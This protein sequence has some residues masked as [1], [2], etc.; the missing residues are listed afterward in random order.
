M[1]YYYDTFYANRDFVHFASDRHYIRQLC[2]LLPQPSTSRVLDVG[3]ARG[4]WTRLFAECGVGSVSGIDNSRVGVTMSHRHFPEGNFVVGDATMLP[5]ADE[6]F[7]MVFCQG[8]SCFNVT[9]LS[10]TVDIGR[11]LLRCLKR[12]GLLVFA[13]TSNMTGKVD[14]K[15]NWV[16]HKPGMLADYLQSL[17]VNVID[18]YVVDRLVFLRLLGG[19]AFA[20][21]CSKALLPAICA[22]T[23]LPALIVVVATPQATSA[24][25]PMATP[26]RT[27]QPA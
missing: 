26:S 23:H 3:S 17:D 12:D 4:Y 7:D 1:S 10:K 25:T 9:D 18:T 20:G 24:A 8:L 11:E 16:H 22:L 5:Y 21:L 14:P 15:R 6:T 2:R 19:H 27:L 13:C